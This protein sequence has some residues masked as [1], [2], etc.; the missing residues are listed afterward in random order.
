MKKPPF[1]YPRDGT[2]RGATLIP[3]IRGALIEAV[4][5]PPA[6]SSPA[7]PGRKGI[8]R[9]GS[10]LPPALFKRFRAI[11]PFIAAFI[12]L[13][14]IGKCNTGLLLCYGNRAG[15]KTRSS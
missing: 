3:R 9:A 2:D 11:F 8:P 14:Q 1:G 12:I 5:G 10:H 7:A 13:H 15:M 6:G 4:S